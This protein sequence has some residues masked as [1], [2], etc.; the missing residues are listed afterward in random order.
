M[1]GKIIFGYVGVMGFQDGV[2]ILVHVMAKIRKDRD[3]II[4]VLVGRGSAYESLRKLAIELGVSDCIRFTGYVD[5]CEVPRYIASFDICVTPDPSNPYNDSCTTIKTM[6]Y[7]AVG[8]PTVA[9]R[10][11]E[12]ENT[13]G[14]SAWYAENNSVD[15]FAE[16]VSKLADLPDQRR[17]MG[18]IGRKRIEESLSWD[19]QKVVLLKAYESLFPNT[20]AL[21]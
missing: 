11:K 20:S 18:Q 13:A 5:F 10:T 3:D 21:V 16:L 1:P 2:D 8:R 17:I 14:E 4:A 19:H 6:E 15:Q 7:M 12:N 9:F